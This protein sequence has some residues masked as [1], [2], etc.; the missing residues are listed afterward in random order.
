VTTSSRDLVW[1][2]SVL[3]HGL[4]FVG[5]EALLRE[6]VLLEWAPGARVHRT[7]AGLALVWSSPRRVRSEHASGLPLVLR[8][9][10]LLAG[11]AEAL[12]AA[13]GGARTRALV[14]AFHGEVVTQPLDAASELDPAAWLALDPLE[15]L[16]LRP[17]P[18]VRPAVASAIAPTPTDAR[19]LLGADVPPTSKQSSELLA[20]LHAQAGAGAAAA[21]PLAARLLGALGGL[22]QR[23][24]QRNDDKSTAAGAGGGKPSSTSALL[25]RPG[26]LLRLRAW[27]SGVIWRSRF[28]ALFGASHARHLHDMLQMFERGQLDEALRHAIP[29]GGPKD[30]ASLPMALRA[31]GARTDLDLRMTATRVDTVTPLSGVHGL[32][33]TLRA[34]YLRA[35]QALRDAGQVEKA[36]FVLV[37]LLQDI[38]GA[39]AYLERVGRFDLAAKLA[40]GRELPPATQVRL[41]ALAGD[42]KRAVLLARRH[43]LFATAI[44]QLGADQLPLELALRRAWADSAAAAGNLLQACDALLA[45]VETRQEALPQ[46]EVCL[47]AGGSLAGGAL[48]RMLQHELGDPEWAS[49]QLETALGLPPEAALPLVVAFAEQVAAGPTSLSLRAPSRRLV[50]FLAGHSSSIGWRRLQRLVPKLVDATGDPALRADLPLVFPMDRAPTACPE[51]PAGTAGLV[52]DARTLP[53]GALLVACGT[54]G[55]RLLSPEGGL[56]H[57]FACAADKLVLSEAGTR[58]IA[59]FRDEG[60]HCLSRLDLVSRREQPWWETTLD[61]F[62]PHFDGDRWVVASEGA[63]LCMDACADGWQALERVPLDGAAVYWVEARGSSA[64]ALLTTGEEQTV[65]LFALASWRCTGRPMFSA[66]VVALLPDPVVASEDEVW[67]PGALPTFRFPIPEGAEVRGVLRDELRAIVWVTSASAACFEVCEAGA[68]GSRERWVALSLDVLARGMRL[69]GDFLTVWDTHG[70]VHSLHLPTASLSAS[71]PIERR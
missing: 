19:E 28:A 67:A 54:E 62:A 13:A 1:R 7:Q 61:A 20:T 38:A 30:T 4:L 9:G 33:L 26:P 60:F 27:L 65:M 10:A 70:R 14:Y 55:V 8:G 31:P 15:V 40:E 50:P 23:I 48:A 21:A 35:F 49:A 58:A 3:A 22:L 44:A 11:P 68:R 43:G 39:V 18:V 32:E 71:L 24:T 45:R 59:V 56:L 41:W 46:L 37:E 34:H 69:D 16:E 6:P 47:A 42:M 29:L 5:D 17:L 51:G 57:H 53:D 63:L 64:A 25:A 12:V 2:G 66:P 52:R 36:A